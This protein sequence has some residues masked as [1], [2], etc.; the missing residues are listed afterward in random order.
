MSV[1]Q[2]GIVAPCRQLSRDYFQKNESEKTSPASARVRRLDSWLA[3][4]GPKKQR[5]CV[6]DDQ[7]ITSARQRSSRLRG[8]IHDCIR[9]L[10]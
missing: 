9:M 7:R 10:R 4:C 6:W 2:F 8:R 1:K 3:A 5:V